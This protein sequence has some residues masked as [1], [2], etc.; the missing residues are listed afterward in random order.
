MEG[1]TYETVAQ[2][3]QTAAMIL[4]IGLFIGVLCYAFWPGNRKRFERAAQLPLQGEP[5]I[6]QNGDEG[7]GQA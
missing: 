3:S 5:D 4:F 2:I 1:L 6:G 7:H